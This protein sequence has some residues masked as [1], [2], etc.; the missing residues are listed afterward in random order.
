M[1]APA[2]EAAEPVKETPAPEQPAAKQPEQNFL[3]KYWWLFVLAIA[4]AAIYFFNKF[5]IVPKVPLAV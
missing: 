2:P 3:Q 4:A 5:K 1:E